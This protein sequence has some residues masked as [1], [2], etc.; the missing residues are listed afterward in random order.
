VAGDL[1]ISDARRSLKVHRVFADFY[2]K[3]PMPLATRVRIHK[4]Y[5]RPNLRWSDGVVLP[6][7]LGRQQWK[8]LDTVQ[9]VGPRTIHWYTYLRG[10]NPRVLL[11]QPE[12]KCVSTARFACN[13][14]QR[15]SKQWAIETQ[16][17]RLSTGQQSL[18]GL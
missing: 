16:T 6:I 5:R 10:K 18:P 3:S 1:R 8:R 11:D 4:V 9:T 13:Q 7:H 17:Y 15:S 2:G 12:V 14:N